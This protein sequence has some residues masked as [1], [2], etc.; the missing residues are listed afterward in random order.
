MTYV[1]A[2]HRHRWAAEL[3]AEDQAAWTVKGSLAHNGAT[4]FALSYVMFDPDEVK[5]SNPHGE[6]WVW[7][8]V[9][10]AVAMSMMSHPSA[11][12]ET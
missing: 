11:R 6:Y 10:E 2:K 7:Q 4:W 1:G 9:S 5:P 3:W 8:D 12:D